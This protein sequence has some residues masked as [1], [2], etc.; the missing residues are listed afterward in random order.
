MRLIDADELIKHQI[1]SDRIQGVLLVVGKGHILSSPTIDTDNI[2]DLQ[3]QASQLQKERD[4]YKADVNILEGKI[5]KA[6][7]ERDKLERQLQAA[8]LSMNYSAVCPWHELSMGC[9]QEPNCNKNTSVAVD[10]WRE[11]W[12]RQ[13]EEAT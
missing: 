11:Y 6:E 9:E 10:C 5:V 3:A 1:E 8:A 2:Y 13:S 7:Q 12:R 4:I